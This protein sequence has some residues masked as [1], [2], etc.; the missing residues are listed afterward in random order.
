VSARG[1]GKRPYARS[2]P[3]ERARKNLAK[4]DK[5]AKVTLDRMSSWGKHSQ[6]DQAMSL[7]R[8]AAELGAATYVK[9]RSLEAAGFV[10][11]PVSAS[12]SFEVGDEVKISP[13]HR[14][15]YLAVY[16]PGVVDDLVVTQVLETGG[17]AV[18]HGRA[19]PF[20]TAK[21]HLERRRRA[22]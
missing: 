8:E 13:K 20:I 11:Q 7:L 12:I 10:P 22:E 17:I 3:I 15:K 2:T 19:T 5:I 4:I 6:L 16:G 9:L 14:E 21:S 1:E 18:R